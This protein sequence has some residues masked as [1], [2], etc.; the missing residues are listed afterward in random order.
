MNFITR[1]KVLPRWIIA[2]L[3]AVII[4][5]SALFGYLFRFN[6][7]F[8]IIGEHDPFIGSLL[9]MLGALI[10]MQFTLSYK[11]I[12]RHTE[13]RDGFIIFQTVFFNFV[14]FISI[15][16]LSLEFLDKGFVIPT[17]VVFIASLASLFNLIFYRL[18]VKEI[19]IYSKNGINSKEMIN[20]VIFGAGE[21][22]MIAQSAIRKDSK[23]KFNTVAFLDDDPQKEGKNIDGKRIY[24]GFQDLELLVKKYQVSELIIAVRILSV[25]RKN[26]IIEECFRLNIS[27]S[28]VPP[29]DKWINGGLTAGEIREVKIEDLLSRDQIL[30]DNPQLNKNIRGKVILVT[31]A[32][33][34]IGSELC[35]QIRYYRPKLIVMLDIAESAIYELQ[36]EFK[37]YFPNCPIQ[38]VLGDIRN[39]EKIREVFKVYNPDLVFHAA[40][41]KHVPMMEFFPEEAVSCIISGTKILADLSVEFGVEKFVM[42]STDKAVNPANVMGACKRIAEMYVQSLNE[43]AQRKSTYRFPTKFVT[44]RFGNV[45]GS[46]GSVIPIFKSQIQSGG[47]VTVTDPEITRYFMTISEAC[48]LVLEAGFIGRGGDIFVFDMG[49]PVKIIDLA[50]KM[51]KLSGKS[52]NKDIQI[53]FTGLRPGEKLFEE[54]LNDFDTL[55]DTHH[56]KIKIAKT[57]TPDYHELNHELGK[58]TNKIN[59]PD[60][61]NLVLQLKELVPEFISSSSTFSKL[62]GVLNK[63]IEKLL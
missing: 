53:L 33:G 13:F 56:P 17:S 24:S 20:G 21:A 50:R 8:T 52:E 40:A 12:V 48:Q 35:R 25:K 30:L 5:I 7:E 6:L 58:L 22:G 63:N 10:I 14:L 57:Y 15:N 28:I 18:V 31:G 32:A 9:F 1:L 62:D 34:S 46:N 36:F 39:T 27:V 61:D 26:Q 2:S 37:S 42:I 43:E 11:G 59:H 54:L 4:F 16:S 60:K 45:L 19:Y 55:L 49:E 3:D 44:T 41:Y 23:N 51:I 38:V 29:V 47:P